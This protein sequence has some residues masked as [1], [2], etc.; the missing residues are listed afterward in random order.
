ML[1]QR[2][3]RTFAVTIAGTH[4][5]I[6]ASTGPRPFPRRALEPRTSAPPRL[7]VRSGRVVLEA[8]EAELA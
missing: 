3:R 8:E 5:A 4:E 7:D 2:G 6:L 1:L